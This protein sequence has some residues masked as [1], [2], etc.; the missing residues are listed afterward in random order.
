MRARP[1][2]KKTMSSSPLYCECLHM[3][4]RLVV[5]QQTNATLGGLGI[6][7]GAWGEYFCEL[8][9]NFC[10]SLVVGSAE[11]HQR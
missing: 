10:I 9:T 1:V 5:V 7:V 2:E 8:I 4:Q 3:T 6:A 11:H